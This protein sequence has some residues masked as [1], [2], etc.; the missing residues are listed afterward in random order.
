MNREYVCLAIPELTEHGWEG[1]VE[2][3]PREELIRCRDC[4]HIWEI[5]KRAV[6]MCKRTSLWT[7]MDG[8]CAWGERRRS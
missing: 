1:M 7:S 6:P 5:D 3:V 4:K 8:F 2:F